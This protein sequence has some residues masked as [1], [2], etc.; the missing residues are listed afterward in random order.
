MD[1]FLDSMLEV[2]AAEPDDDRDSKDVGAVAIYG[3]VG[4]IDYVT[5]DRNLYDRPGNSPPVEGT[6][7]PDYQVVAVLEVDLPFR[8][9]YSG[10]HGEWRWIASEGPP[11]LHITQPGKR[12]ITAVSTVSQPLGWHGH[13]GRT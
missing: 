1:V 4:D 12:W 8:Y 3:I 9:V 6:E 13:W 5:F 2:V 7:W 10:Q 11:A